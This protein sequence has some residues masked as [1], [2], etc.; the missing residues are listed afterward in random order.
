MGFCFMELSFKELKKREVINV[1]DGSSLGSIT[2]ITISFPTGIFTTI[3]VPGKR[4]GF[5]SSIFSKSEMT[6]PRNKIQKIGSDVILVNLNCGDTCSESVLANPK[7]EPP[8]C[9]PLFSP[10]SNDAKI[11]MGD[12]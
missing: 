12:Y 8:P 5:F 9:K 7:K 10:C 6:I 4:Q 11:D 1:A 3:T 2:D